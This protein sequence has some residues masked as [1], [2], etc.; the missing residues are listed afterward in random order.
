MFGYLG[1]CLTGHSGSTDM[2]IPQK[3]E[4]TRQGCSHRNS[5]TKESKEV[6]VNFSGIG[7]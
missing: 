2:C 5:G 4:Q 3:H 6:D 1:H 7:R